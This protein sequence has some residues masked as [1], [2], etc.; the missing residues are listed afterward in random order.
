M[1]IYEFTCKACGRRF[2]RLLG[3]VANTQPLA[4][5]HCGSQNIVR[6]ISRFARVRSEADA[7]DAIA[8]TVESTGEEDPATLRRL[9]KDMTSALGEDMDD[10]IEELIE[11]DAMGSEG[12]LS[13][14]DA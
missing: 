10:E 13:D 4:C 12:D 11:H 6:L 8:D 9:M 7:L 14:T 5:T 1:P 2:K 3:V